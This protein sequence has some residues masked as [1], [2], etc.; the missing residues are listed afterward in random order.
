MFQ[1]IK[2]ENKRQTC[3]STWNSLKTIF[4]FDEA[5]INRKVLVDAGFQLEWCE[6]EIK[7]TKE[8]LRAFTSYLLEFFPIAD[9]QEI[10]RI[11]NSIYSQINGIMQLAPADNGAFSNFNSCKHYLKD[12]SLQ[13]IIELRSQLS[14]AA[15]L[16]YLSSG[17]K[18]FVDNQLSES[19]SKFESKSEEFNK[20]VAEKVD[21]INT[22]EESIT[23]KH[24]EVSELLA[25]KTI[26]KQSDGFSTQAGAS[27]D[28]AK[29]WLKASIGMS[30]FLCALPFIF[31]WDLVN[32]MFKGVSNEQAI[33]S[34]SMIFAIVAYALLQC[35][36][37]W[38]ANRHNQVINV[39]RTNSLKTFKILADAVVAQE[40]KDAILSK[41]V[42]S[43]FAHQET[44]FIKN[45]TSP[46][47]GGQAIEFFQKIVGS[48]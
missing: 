46:P 14:L 9:L 11:A 6:E 29:N 8:L 25:V 35:V 10:Q 20:I 28:A 26:E 41:A 18:K 19:L 38:N 33:L 3:E 37:S 2:D 42:D 4:D 7:K 36:K 1:N 27:E 30:V 12:R 16:S 39:Q 31:L 44:G 23:T 43:I 40:S 32:N 21:Y 24:K 5:S 47:P 17:E 34:K 13:T 48:N 15:T 22:V 45:S